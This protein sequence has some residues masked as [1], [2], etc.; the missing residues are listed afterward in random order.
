MNTLFDSDINSWAEQNNYNKQLKY[1]NI[2]KNS[3]CVCLS[4]NFY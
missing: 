3:H 2:L 1:K 4:V